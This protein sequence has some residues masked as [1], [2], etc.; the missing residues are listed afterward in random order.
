MM[1]LAFHFNF[2]SFRLLTSVS[3]DSS[4]KSDSL[5]DFGYRSGAN[6]TKSFA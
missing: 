3:A 2:F 4:N 6:I 1:R 5:T